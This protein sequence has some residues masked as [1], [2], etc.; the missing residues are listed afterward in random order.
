MTCRK[1]IRAQDFVREFRAG[2]TDVQLM[3]IFGL[4]STEQLN[5]IFRKLLDSGILNE[6]DLANR[7]TERIPDVVDR[8]LRRFR[9]SKPLGN[10][11]VYDM[12]DV[13]SEFIVMDISEDGIKVGRIKS[14]RGEK[15]TFLIKALEFDEMQTFSFDAVCRWANRG[16]AG[17][18]ITSISPS[19]A[20]QLKRF[21][22]RFTFCED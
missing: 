4:T 17:F 13:F 9:R 8:D 16:M 5:S 6:F 7:T 2:M 18:A 22:N 14:V 20:I 21:I 15:R 1:R 11:P 19:A 10:V 12:N 3:K